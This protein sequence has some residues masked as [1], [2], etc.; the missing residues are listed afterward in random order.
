MTEC[1]VCGREASRLYVCCECGRL[2]CDLCH[3]HTAD[4]SILSFALVFYA[5]ASESQMRK[6]TETVGC[7]WGLS[8][9]RIV[10]KFHQLCC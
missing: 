4:G 6:E 2:V 8:S 1:A 10:F 3:H 5:Q 9:R 7:H